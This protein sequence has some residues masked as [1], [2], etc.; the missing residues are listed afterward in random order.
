MAKRSFIKRVSILGGEPLADKNLEEVL[1]LVNKIRLLL[2]EKTIWIYTGY[3]W[4]E[5]NINPTRRE[6]VSKCDILVD[7][8]YENSLKDN[9]LKWRGSSN[10]RVI[11]VQQSIRDGQLRLYT[12]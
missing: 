4:E 9:T 8:R 7:G 12:Q 10:Q 1:N 2:P 5:I 11:D 3:I 6:I